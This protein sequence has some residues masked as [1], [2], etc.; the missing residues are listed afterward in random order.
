MTFVT[1][2]FML[3]IGHAVAD[4]ALQ[5]E[6]MAKGKNRHRRP[7]V[8]PEGQ[9]YCACWPYWLASHA[10]IHGGVVWAVTQNMWLGVAE[11]V[12]HFVIDFIKCDNITN[13]H[14]DQAMH[15]VCRVGYALWSVK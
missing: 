7:A 8:I 13:P 4:F 6:V 2:L 14:Q 1:R 15:F 10:F 3:L 9:K 5:S 12:A 11:V